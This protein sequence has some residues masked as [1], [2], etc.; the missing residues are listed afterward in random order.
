M[1]VRDG[2]RFLTPSARR[3]TRHS[4]YACPTPPTAQHGPLQRVF[5]V[6]GDRWGS[7]MEHDE[8]GG[9]EDVDAGSDAEMGDV[10]GAG[11][12]GSGVGGS[13]Q[14]TGGER[15]GAGA[16]GKAG[17]PSTAE[18]RRSAAGGGRRR[19]RQKARADRWTRPDD[20][21]DSDGADGGDAPA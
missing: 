13:G 6:G 5:G 18:E 2:A 21:D 1:T 12:A 20:A 8:G 17:R 16:A 19:K 14:D 3:E 4:T 7:D 15:A 9:G 11:G 10:G